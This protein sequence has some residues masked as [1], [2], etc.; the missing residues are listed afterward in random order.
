MIP[1]LQNNNR[2]EEIKTPNNEY[3]LSK[4]QSYKNVSVSNLQ[5]CKKVR[6]VPIHAAF[7]KA[8]LYVIQR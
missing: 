4:D 3:V 1:C 2:W 5:T 8:H 7:G 6:A